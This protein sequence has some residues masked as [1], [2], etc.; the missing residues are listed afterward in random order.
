MQKNTARNATAILLAPPHNL[1]TAITS[2]PR[3]EAP[4]A[5]MSYIPKYSPDFSGG[6][7]LEKYERDND[8]IDPWKHPIPNAR[9]ANPRRLFKVIAYKHT[10]K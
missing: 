1:T 8:C 2:E 10:K 3:N 4:F 6:I 9:I 7:I 5:K